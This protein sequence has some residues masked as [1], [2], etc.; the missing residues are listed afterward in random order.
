LAT[1]D[2]QVLAG[3]QRLYAAV[4]LA[5]KARMDPAAQRPDQQHRR[6]EMNAAEKAKVNFCFLR[7]RQK[8][9]T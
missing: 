3:K 4:E 8:K 9:P 1:G 2:S 5:D 7:M 6:G